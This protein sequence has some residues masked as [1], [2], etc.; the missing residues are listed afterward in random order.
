M[1]RSRD[2]DE[3]GA[4][5]DLF[6]TTELVFSDLIVVESDIEGFESDLFKT[7]TE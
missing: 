1:R 3:R 2:F 5:A 7:N 4:R 6:R